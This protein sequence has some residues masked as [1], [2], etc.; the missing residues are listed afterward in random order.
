MNYFDKLK[1]IFT[2]AFNNSSGLKEGGSIKLAVSDYKNISIEEGMNVEAVRWKLPASF[3]FGTNTI[4]ADG[5][6]PG[7]SLAAVLVG[8]KTCPLGV[9]WYVRGVSGYISSPC[10]F[11]IDNGLANSGYKAPQTGSFFIPVENL[12][13]PSEPVFASIQGPIDPTVTKVVTAG[14]WGIDAFSSDT[15]YLAKHKV[16]FVADSNT[17]GTSMQNGK[18]KEDLYS[19]KFVNWLL[20]NGVSAR[21]IEK[22]IGGKSSTDYNN[23][24]NQGKLDINGV[25]LIVYG[26]GMNDLTGVGAESSSVTTY[27]ANLDNFI[28]W[29]KKKYPNAILIVCSPFITS[30]G[31]A[32]E[33]WLAN[34]L[35]P[36][37]AT[38]ITTTADPNILYLN[39][40]GVISAP[41]N[42]ANSGDTYFS[43]NDSSTPNNRVH[44][45]KAGHEIDFALMRDFAIANDIITKLNAM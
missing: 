17:Q 9:I 25:S 43:D 40:A 44:H 31:S 24:L 21:R 15:N 18:T 29:K 11:Q 7:T 32:K 33:L 5:A 42:F 28:L 38:K 1:Q 13:Y 37:I 23:F 2:E 45:N 4:A 19:Q 16:L 22:S 34:Y 26:L 27:L 20:E 36:A 41:Y 3:T 12:V 35:R 30:N 10:F 14:Q 8:G 6:S 39:F